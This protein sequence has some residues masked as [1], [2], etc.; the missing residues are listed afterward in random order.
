[1]KMPS[2]ELVVAGPETQ[3]LHV[4]SGEWVPGGM[5]EEVSMLRLIGAKFLLLEKGFANTEQ[6]KRERIL[7]R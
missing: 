6:G 4:L 7:R 5:S 3:R 1:M 2:S